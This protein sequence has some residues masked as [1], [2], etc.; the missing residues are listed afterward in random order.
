M[1]VDKPAPQWKHKKEADPT[2]AKKVEASSA[3]E[4][5][6]AAIFTKGEHLI[7]KTI[8]TTWTVMLNTMT[9][10]RSAILNKMTMTIWLIMSTK[11]TAIMEQEFRTGIKE[12]KSN[13]VADAN[14]TYDF[15]IPLD[16]EYYE[17]AKDRI[18]MLII[19]YENAR[20]RFHKKDLEISD[21]L[22]REIKLINTALEDLKR[23]TNLIPEFGGQAN[24]PREKRQILA[25]GASL[26]S[27]LLGNALNL[28]GD[29]NKLSDLEEK[30]RI[31][32]E[33]N[34]EFE[35]EQ[36]GVNNELSRQII[37]LNK[38]IREID[39]ED[40]KYR[41]LVDRKNSIKSLMSTLK[42]S[43]HRVSELIKGAING[44]IG[45]ILEF[46][47]KIKQAI[48]MVEE[49]SRSKAYLKNL[50]IY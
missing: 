47:E 49:N 39:N 33:N 46:P 28:D 22:R 1:E 30:Y 45:T 36:I 15:I 34:L 4:D 20:R 26:A 5:K 41:V 32:S 40:E 50:G 24:T 3:T 42:D 27:F 19:E 21:D 44:E 11:I 48:K 13:K 35:K 23:L 14:E 9:N 37:K 29:S 18:T 43:I 17:K 7:R 16:L 12:M 6:E 2:T 8:L 31:F 10:T 38:R 25:I